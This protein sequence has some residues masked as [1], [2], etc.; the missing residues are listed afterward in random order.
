MSFLNGKLH[1]SIEMLKT[2]PEPCRMPSTS[3]DIKDKQ[4]IVPEWLH[5]Q[6]TGSLRFP[7]RG[8]MKHVLDVLWISFTFELLWFFPTT[9]CILSILVFHLKIEVNHA[10]VQPRR[11]QMANLI[12]Y[13]CRMESIWV[14]TP[15]RNEMKFSF[16]FFWRYFVEI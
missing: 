11:K 2:M 16:G 14:V 7:S 10:K 6:L 5:H 1:Y 12:A 8:P 4:F 15:W 3:G 9:R 13:L